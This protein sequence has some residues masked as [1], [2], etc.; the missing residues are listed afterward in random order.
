MEDFYNS[1][2]LVKKWLP[3][4][5]LRL[6]LGVA[7]GIRRAW[8]SVTRARSSGCGALAFPGPAQRCYGSPVFL[9]PPGETKAV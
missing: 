1:P 5:I 2:A 8:L 7:C 3:A 6:S 9:H 4:G